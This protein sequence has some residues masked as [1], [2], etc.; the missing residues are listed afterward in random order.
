MQDGTSESRGSA[1]AAHPG[2]RTL[3][4][5]ALRRHV[6]NEEVDLLTIPET[7]APRQ[8]EGNSKSPPIKH[9]TVKA[10]PRFGRRKQQ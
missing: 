8:D 1:T 5:V 3:E 6:S 9:P 10:A 7:D 2:S 4:T